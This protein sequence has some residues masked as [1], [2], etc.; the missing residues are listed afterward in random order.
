MTKTSILL[1]LIDFIKGKE[2]YYD[3]IHLLVSNQKTELNSQLMNINIEKIP[4][5]IDDYYVEEIQLS[6]S[7]TNALSGIY[8][9]PIYINNIN[10]LCGQINLKANFCFEIIYYNSNIMNLPKYFNFIDNNNNKIIKI[11]KFDN[12]GIPNVIRFSFINIDK[13]QLNVKD[14]NFHLARSKNSGSYLISD[15]TINN[16]HEIRIHRRRRNIYKLLNDN[17]L[18]IN[19]FSENCLNIYNQ[20]KEKCENLSN[21]QY[22]QYLSNIC[23]QIT[24]DYNKFTEKI[25]NI[26]HYV[27]YPHDKS[28]LTE[29]EFKCC[30]VY[31][32]IELIKAYTKISI[33]IDFFEMS[34][35]IL[36]E[37]NLTYE[38]KTNLLF[39]FF[40]KS[41]ERVICFSDCEIVNFKKINKESAYFKAHQLVKNIMEKL[42]LN[43][44]L[45]KF[46]YLCNS[47]CGANRLKK[48][49]KSFRLSM[50]SEDIIKTHLI[51]LLP[52]ACFRYYEKDRIASAVI[53]TEDKVAF[54]NE[55]NLFN[56]SFE[57]LDDL[58]LKNNDNECKYTIPLVMII[59]HEYYGYSKNDFHYKKVNYPNFINSNKNFTFPNEDIKKETE[60][61]K[62]SLPI[63]GGESGRSL[64]FLISSDRKIIYT[65]KFSYISMKELLDVNLWIS[66]D[67]SELNK[68]M[69]EKI[70]ANNLKFDDKKFNNKLPG[71][72]EEEDIKE[73]VN[74]NEQVTYSS[75]D[76]YDSDDFRMSEIKN[77]KNYFSDV[78]IC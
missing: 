27:K 13:K 61:K 76:N 40:R 68:I 77:K 29:K 38:T 47:G 8:F 23:N 7:K 34:L 58:L 57:E 37:E 55:G 41:R 12:F 19:D 1:Y 32:L 60:I 3:Q 44:K 73:K 43:S 36:K 63:L 33:A 35:K 21:N 59:L 54:F 46:F 45:F 74:T 51:K 48:E 62:Y 70:R 71:F 18:N 52:D 11:D 5:F 50:M 39:A 78:K 69:N 17:S 42:S 9:I 64:E 16:F 72:Q 10:A 4:S 26:R 6:N 31:G 65:L 2:H 30:A 66:K 25:F 67:F 56:E 24:F 22:K 49:K 75:D 28:I 20:N 53:F 15:F 14:L